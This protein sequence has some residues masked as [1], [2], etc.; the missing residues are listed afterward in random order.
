MQRC[1]RCRRCQH[2]PCHASELA[3]RTGNKYDELARPPLNSRRPA[4]PPPSYSSTPQGSQP[5]GK[6]VPLFTPSR[7]PRPSPPLQGRGRRSG[8]G[9]SQQNLSGAS[10]RCQRSLEAILTHFERRNFQSFSHTNSVGTQQLGLP[11]DQ[12]LA[13]PCSLCPARSRISADSTDCRV[14]SSSTITD[15]AGGRT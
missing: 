1:L 13:P 4:L 11:N 5:P 6:H 10:A 3:Y 15:Q 12:K 14:P 2:A 9:C 7:C 8:R